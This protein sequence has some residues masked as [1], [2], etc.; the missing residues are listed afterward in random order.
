MVYLYCTNLMLHG[1]SV[2]CG[3]PS[4]HGVTNS[5]KRYYLCTGSSMTQ[6]RMI[7]NIDS[8]L[9]V[10]RVVEIV[11]PLSNKAAPEIEREL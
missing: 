9:F 6:G 4:L 10:L 3:S 2:E 8:V 1:I 11:T 7:R 5:S